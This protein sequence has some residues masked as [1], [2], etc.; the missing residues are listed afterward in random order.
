MTKELEMLN[1]P[2]SVTKIASTAFEGSGV[3]SVT[4][5]DCVSCN[6][7]LI[8]RGTIVH[9]FGSPSQVVIPSSVREI[10][11]GPFECDDFLVDLSFEEGVVS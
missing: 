8:H 7:L 2:G 1:L 11:E 9:C 6:S 3:T 10:E 4:G 5:A